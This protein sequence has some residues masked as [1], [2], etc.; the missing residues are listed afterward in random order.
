MGRIFFIGMHNKPG[1]GALDSKT[2][3]GKI[4]DEIISR[5]PDRECIK[6]NL[7]D[8]EY[9]PTEFREIMAASL[10]WD[11]QY[12]PTD[13]DLLVLLGK[14]VDKNIAF[15]DYLPVVRLTHPAARIVTSNRQKYIDESVQKI[16]SATNVL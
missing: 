9:L 16:K 4:V 7:C 10:I 11:K 13:E 15:G 6:T 8:T 14:W 2:M 5:L 12:K 3:T 1:M